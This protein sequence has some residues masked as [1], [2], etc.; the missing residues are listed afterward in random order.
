MVVQSGTLHF[1]GPHVTVPTTAGPLTVPVPLTLLTVPV[2]LTLLTVPQTD[3]TLGVLTDWRGSHQSRPLG[4]TDGDSALRAFRGT[5]S[6]R[7]Q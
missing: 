3:L 7:L 5:D 2:S 1:L 6:H 4:W